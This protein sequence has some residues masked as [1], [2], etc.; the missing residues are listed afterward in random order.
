MNELYEIRP[1]AHIRSDFKQ[2]YGI[3]RQPRLVKGLVAEIVFDSEFNNQDA[4][5]GLEE[6]S[7]IWLV[8][9]FSENMIDMSVAP[10][11]WSPLV[12]PPRL[13]GEI[14]KGVFATRSPYRPNSL[15]LSAVEL[16]E[17]VINEKGVKLIVGGADLLD[18]TPIFDIKPYIPFSDSIPTASSSFAG[19]G[20]NQAAQNKDHNKGI[21]Q[22]KELEVVFPKE[23]L[24]L[25]KKK[26]QETLINILKIDPRDAYD[27]KH[28]HICKMVFD[29]VDVSFVVENGVLKVVEVRKL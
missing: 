29:D 25:V 24:K 1:I 19:P 28:S 18:G 27:K 9:G 3:P 17:V 13:G 4:V 10:V 22:P 16:K 5:R 12:R 21:D 7:H 11:K 26:K 8:W 2:K 15:G 14:K 23:L 20:N 6:F